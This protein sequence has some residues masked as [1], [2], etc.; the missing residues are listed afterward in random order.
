MISFNKILLFTATITMMMVGETSARIISSSSAV[1]EIQQEDGTC[2]LNCGSCTNDNV[3]VTFLDFLD[4]SIF[5]MF[6]QG[7][8]VCLPLALAQLAEDTNLGVCCAAA[9]D[10]EPPVLEGGLN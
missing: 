1:V 6:W 10:A 8:I 9:D 4:L 3:E 7:V 2:E 5:D